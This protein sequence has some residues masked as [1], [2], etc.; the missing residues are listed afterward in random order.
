[1][2]GALIQDSL[3]VAPSEACGAA[4]GVVV[5]PVFAGTSVKARTAGTIINIDFAALAGESCTAAAHTHAPLEQTQTTCKDREWT[6]SKNTN[7][8]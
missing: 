2:E 7:G 3:A 5:D 4:A 6:I 1:M 8:K